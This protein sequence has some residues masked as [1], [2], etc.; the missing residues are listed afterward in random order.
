MRYLATIQKIKEITPIEC[1]DLIVLLSF[2]KI[3]WV[4]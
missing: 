4:I 2:Y 1:K 3:G